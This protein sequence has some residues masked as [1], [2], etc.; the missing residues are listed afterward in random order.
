MLTDDQMRSQMI[1][2]WRS[3]GNETPCGSGSRSVNTVNARDM[4]RQVLLNPDYSIKTVIDAGA[5]DLYAWKG[6][7]WSEFGVAYRPYDLIPRVA[8]VTAFD[9]TRDVLPNADLIICRLV[10]NHL[11]PGRIEM[12]LNNFVLSGARYLLATQFNT[13]DVHENSRDFFQLDLCSTFGEPLEI[14]P[15]GSDPACRLALFKMPEGG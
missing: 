1:N 11:G 5:G 14:V 10:L 7:N 3:G 2:G 13:K 4:I 9:I 8:G 12:A 6:I 15:D